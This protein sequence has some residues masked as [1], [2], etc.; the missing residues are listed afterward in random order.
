ML[1]FLTVG[2]YLLVHGYQVKDTIF[3]HGVQFSIMVFD[4]EQ[5]NFSVDKFLLWQ[6]LQVNICFLIV[7]KNV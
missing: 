5:I 7:G 3:Y 6:I 2:K 4:H 1:W